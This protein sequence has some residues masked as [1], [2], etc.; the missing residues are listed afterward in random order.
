MSQ[1]PSTPAIRD[2]RQ[3]VLHRIFGLD[4]RRLL[5]NCEDGA[6]ASVFKVGLESHLCA[7][8]ELALHVQLHQPPRQGASLPSVNSI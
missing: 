7:G 2:V 4:R 3:C 8:S 6:L 1:S 5:A